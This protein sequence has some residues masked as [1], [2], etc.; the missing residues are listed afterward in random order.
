M[1]ERTNDNKRIRMGKGVLVPTYKCN[2]RCTCCYASSE[3]EK[4]CKYMSMEEAKKSVNFFEMIG[5][6][7]FTWLGGE[8]TVYPYLI[9]ITKYAY[10]K[11][12][13]SWI[14][15]N[16][17]R[18]Q[19]KNY[20]DMLV[21]CGVMGGCISIF[22]MNKEKQEKIINVKGSHDYLMKALNNTI[23][24]FWPFHP[25]I[26][27][28]I[29]NYDECI[30]DIKK[31][32][33]MGFQKIYINYGIPN[34]AVNQDMRFSETPEKLAKLTEKLFLMQKDTGL[35]FIFNCEKNKIPICYFDE[36]IF[37]NLV[38]NHQIGYGCELI[39]GNTIV[40]E[41][42][43]DVLGCSHWVGHKLMNIYKDYSE[44]KLKS[45]EEF[46]DEWLNSYPKDFRAMYAGFPSKKCRYCSVRK[47]G[48]C[49][50]GCKTWQKIGK[51]KLV[52]SFE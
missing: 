13:T 31:L 48:K 4:E 15:T 46:W 6:K 16:G 34:V 11:G 19:D 25:M 38:K 32:K 21:S 8:P 10:Q 2:Q 36:N 22:S 27:I 9:D 40:I 39:K 45:C 18:L 30:E 12:I 37:Q 52:C 24:N 1:Q 49:Y 44:L 29:D 3:I 35:K 28:G 26:T 42:G 33:N 20:G 51:V 47:E 50:G 5:I 23:E 7:T 43:G 41:P 17:I 14:V